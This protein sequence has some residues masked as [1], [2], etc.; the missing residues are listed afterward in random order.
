[1]KIYN[2]SASSSLFIV[3][4]RSAP[5]IRRWSIISIYFTAKNVSNKQILLQQC[6]KYDEQSNKKKSVKEKEKSRC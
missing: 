5:R 4:K 2:I 3:V 6:I 1:M